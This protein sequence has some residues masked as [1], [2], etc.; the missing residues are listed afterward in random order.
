LYLSDAASNIAVKVAEGSVVWL[1]AD[2][3]GSAVGGEA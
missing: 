1:L 3:W 2:M